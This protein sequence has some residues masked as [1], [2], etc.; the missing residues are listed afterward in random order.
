MKKGDLVIMP[1]EVRDEGDKPR[2]GVV[3][4][5][6]SPPVARLLRRAYRIGILWSDGDGRIDYEPIDWLEKINAKG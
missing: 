5:S 3:V 4:K 2:V 1:G 6:P